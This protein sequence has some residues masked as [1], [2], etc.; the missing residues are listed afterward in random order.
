M[1]LSTCRLVQSLIHLRSKLDYGYV[2]KTLDQVCANDSQK[3]KYMLTRVSVES[4][5]ITRVTVVIASQSSSKPLTK[6]A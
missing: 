6:V 3:S 1:L 5:G 4:V 2:V